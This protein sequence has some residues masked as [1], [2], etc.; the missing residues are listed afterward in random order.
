MSTL[1]GFIIRTTGSTTLLSKEL[2]FTVEDEVHIQQ[3]LKYNLEANGYKVLVFESGESFLN[4]VKNTVPDLFILDI[5]LPGMDGLEVCRQLKA[6]PRTKT[7]PI[8]MLT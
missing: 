1:Q 7:V 2:I 8:M 4:E 3:L 6:N 5:M